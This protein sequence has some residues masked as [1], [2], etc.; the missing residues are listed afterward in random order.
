MSEGKSAPTVPLMADV[1][2]RGASEHNLKNVDL[3]FPR[4]RLV[5][6]T[7]V[8]G[9][10]KSSL[11][12]D[13]IYKEGQRRFLESLSSYARQ[14]MG[15]IEKPRVEHVEGLSPTVAIDQKS[16]S[17]NPRSTVGTITEVWD[18]LRLMMAR[19]G[20]PRCHVCDAEVVAF[21]PEQIVDEILAAGREGDALLVLA[22]LVRGRKGSYRKELI[23]LRQKGYVRARIDGQVLRLEEDIQ[24]DRYKK[25][26]I[27]VVLDR[28]KLGPERRARL[29]E[30]VS[31]AL[32]LGGGFAGTLL[33]PGTADEVHRTWSSLRACPEGH[34]A[35][36]EL[37]P[38]LFSF[39]SPQG[40]CPT[41]DGL[42]ETRGFS[43]T[44]LVADAA[45]S[46]RDGA[47]HCFNKKGFVHYTRIHLDHLD[48]VLVDYGASV[49]TPLED[50]PAEAAS[51]LWNGS[52]E[53][54][55]DFRFVTKSEG[56]GVRGLDRRPFDGILG[57]LSF[58][59]RE[60]RPKSL[61]RFQA[62]LPCPACR[63]KRLRKE[64]L[65][66][67]FDGLE[68][69]E[70]ASQ[71]I[72]AAH[73]WLQAAW[74]RIE[75][76]G[77]KDFA[78]GRELFRE[79]LDRLDFLER[80]GL[81]YLE[82]GRS[83]ATLSGGESQRIRLAAQVGSGLRGILYVLDEPS[84]GLHPRDNDRLIETLRELRDRGN[85]VCV[86]EH[87]EDTMRASDFLVD[88]GPGAGV[89]GGHV[90]ASGTPAEVIA[91]PAST[92]A[93]WLDGRRHIVIPERRPKA[94]ACLRIVGATQHNLK[95]IDVEIPL[96]L[97]V[98]VAGVSGSGKSSLVHHVLHRA[99][100]RELNGAD[101]LPGDHERIEGMDLLDKVIE[102]DQ[103][104]I[105]RTP[106]SN[107][108]TYS[109]LWNE[110]RDLYASLPESEMRGYAKGRF[111]F[112]VKG[113]RCEACEGAGVRLL[114]MQ[115]LEAVEV[116]C[117]TCEGR[118]FNRETLEI[119]FK[120]CSI[121]D[122][123]EMSISE[124]RRFFAAHPKIERILSVLED[125]GLG[126]LTL[127]QTS[128]TL[129]GGEAQRVKLATELARPATGRTFY[130]LDEPTTGLHFEDIERLL[131]ALQRLV[132]AGNS[133]LVVEHNLEVLKSVDWILE[134][135]PEGGG[136]GGFVVASGRPED[137]AKVPES[138]T[139]RALAPYVSKRRRALAK[140]EPRAPLS[141]E[142]KALRVVGARQNNL[143]AID[144]EF[145]AA[146]FSVVTGVSGS[147]KTSLAFD[148]L[149]REG[150]RRFIESLSTYA[151]RFLGRLD[152]APVDKIEGLL[153]A[154]AID[155][156]SAGRNPR[157]T[158][159]TAT[160]IL[161]YL[162]L[163]FARVGQ[164][165]C[166]EH[167]EPLVRNS[168]STLAGRV[169]AAYDGKKGY[170]L[171]PVAVRAG[172]EER[173]LRAF[174]VERAQMW[175]EDGFAR[176]A[177]AHEDT[178]TEHGLEAAET[179]DLEAVR[180]GLW[181]VVDR[182][183]FGPRSRTRLAEAFELAGRHGKGFV[184]VAP[185]DEA[186]TT[187][188]L[189]R[190]CTHCGFHLPLDLHPR[191]FSFNHHRGAC[192][193]CQGLGS[194]LR[195]Q[196]ELLIAKP[197]RPLFAGALRSDLG[198]GPSY[199]FHPTRSFAKTA[200]AMAAAHGF[201]LAK[202]PWSKLTARQQALVFDGS[203]EQSFA[204][205]VRREHGASTRSYELDA[206]W[207]GLRPMLEEKYGSSDS[208]SL[209]QGLSAVFREEACSTCHGS[210]LH[211]AALAVT[212]AGR[213]IA[214]LAS[215][216]VQDLVA[217]FAGLDLDG[218]AKTIADQV[219]QE[220]RS[221]LGFLDAMGLGYLELDRSAATLS[222]GEAQRIR[223]AGQLGSKLTGT[224][225]VLDEPTVGLHPRD[226]ERLLESLLGLKELG[227]TVVAVEHDETVMRRADWVV[228][229]GPGAGRHG[230]RVVHQGTPASLEACDASLTG[231]WLRGEASLPRREQRRSTSGAALHIEGVAVHNLRG[232]EARFPLG[233]LTCVTGVSGS[234]KSSLVLE[235]LVPALR[236]EQGAWKLRGKEAVK[237]LIVVDQDALS[238]TPTS[239]AA[240]YVGIWTAVR[241]LFAQTEVAR[242]KGFGPGRFSFNS[243][244][245]RCPQCE[246]RG[247][248]QIEM[249][250]L[251]DV[252]VRC[253][254]CHGRR[255]DEQT[256]EV[257]FRDKS[258]ADV[259]ALECG[260]A[261]ELFHNQ[262]RIRAPLRTLVDVGLGYLT[263][264]QG[265]HTLSGGEAQRLKLAAELCKPPRPGRVYVLDE[266][267]TG[268]HMEDTKRLVEV[269]DKLVD[270]GATVIVIEHH[271]G[272]A[273]AA[274]WVVDL[275]PEAGPLGGRVV[276]C[277]SPESVAA[278][279][280]SVTAPHLAAELV[281][282][283][284]TVTSHS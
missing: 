13:T 182:V 101:V 56:R 105:G 246:G 142:A 25:H 207:P 110:V 50:L 209:R 245:G 116:A 77:G 156:K 52:G 238:A 278:A 194:K 51:V 263:L 126:Y 172:L 187:W 23:E 221:R 184:A 3:R 191:F 71:S 159:G 170:V 201:D 228:D 267:T 95:R 70:I 7:G 46:L 133:V 260:E 108:A 113:G 115:F 138:P 258:I 8:S 153:P 248:L 257:R 282:R 168:P 114:E 272:V 175:K 43:T 174:V 34:G 31:A 166:P 144:A 62:S 123:L 118:R 150:Q 186:V 39:N 178:I 219:L 28:L 45:K 233:A 158:V 215:R 134:L 55:W 89:L 218:E 280:A 48:Q 111:S 242:R 154:I 26:D 243:K 75:A 214:D 190:S 200:I 5:C 241:E 163:L 253:D 20:T 196:K 230:G 58:V 17:R 212:V 146:S 235:A 231:A 137:I 216:S 19:L 281:R 180:R 151:R 213:N 99:L 76:R 165:H 127:G 273:A 270:G 69:T 176:F 148:T 250:F 188:S 86:V 106:R 59:E 254:L 167:G 271:M 277:G 161:D 262:R 38:R 22:P 189:E 21:A 100:A 97:F 90:V 152:R 15:R 139:G 136:A 183:S 9:S 204:V 210:R 6:F 60:W 269:L 112:N 82:L 251:A 109:K 54:V 16:V 98:G 53:R 171:A 192:P 211:P 96:G 30:S 33:H 135:G 88:V 237:D 78:I 284:P 36:P 122:V 104:P 147:G 14:F 195:L 63:G 124:A 256:L 84:I 65:A 225:Y 119:L 259:L 197:S 102:I 268:L 40:A 279:T 193:D 128:T 181:L 157:S 35:I 232:V 73:A 261:M 29:L 11:A 265:L 223:L 203:G 130:I 162:R 236:G 1:V 27:E 283:I 2:L 140:V 249:H 208:V 131:A 24:L 64:A 72:E 117:E 42:G 202:T 125:V 47:L 91:D 81:G 198:P 141:S 222:G 224:L 199:L 107:P 103:S 164:P 129:S 149:F 227:N 85:T 255:F 41:C 12:Y 4:D 49:D 83:A 226:T 37:E 67:R 18:Y 247:E 121:H 120:G 179:C 74:K 205:K 217:F 275:G 229:I 206:T 132:D 57:T 220:L 177:L 44:L 68:I 94:K 252:W 79:L 173:D 32:A 276:A 169:S 92:T 87:D 10:G 244:E 66:V 264:G 155:Q 240:T 234:G 145:P 143:Q 239:T 80:V 160:E 266:P 93:P 185:R 274:D 61:Q